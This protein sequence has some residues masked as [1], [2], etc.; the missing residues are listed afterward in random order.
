MIVRQ[1]RNRDRRFAPRG[2]SLHLID[3]ENLAG[4][5]GHIPEALA[6][7]RARSHFRPGDHVVIAARPSVALAAKR[8]WP[9][10]LVRCAHGVDGADLAL[11]AEALP[12]DLARRFS[13]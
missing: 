10:A 5:D 3:I 8:S 1:R 13:R 12:A 9:S 6:S 7:Y 2:R 4:P 11:L